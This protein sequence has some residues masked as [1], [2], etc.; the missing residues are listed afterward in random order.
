MKYALTIQNYPA[1]IVLLRRALCA[2]DSH[3]F[4]SVCFDRKWK[5]EK[6]MEK[7]REMKRSG[8]GNKYIFVV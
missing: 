4:F 8:K 2:Y 1:S 6:W 5:K 3:I 7:E